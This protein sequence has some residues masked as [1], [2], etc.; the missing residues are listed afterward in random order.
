MSSSV[1]ITEHNYI[2][3]ELINNF[4]WCLEQRKLRTMEA[5][6]TILTGKNY[7]FL[8]WKKLVPCV[9]KIRL[10]LKFYQVHVWK[11]TEICIVTTNIKW[12]RRHCSDYQAFK[13]FSAMIFLKKRILFF[14]HPLYPMFIS[15]VGWCYN[16]SSVV[17]I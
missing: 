8:R 3:Q 15:S 7:Q 10:S 16:S 5:C 2:V 9:A 4:Q 14:K 17:I 13:S 12:I 1:I 11:E 6:T